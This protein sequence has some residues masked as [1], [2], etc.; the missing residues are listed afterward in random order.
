MKTHLHNDD[1]D[2][3]KVDGQ[4]QR[5]EVTY[6]RLRRRRH[7]GHKQISTHQQSSVIRLTQ[8]HSSSR[9]SV[10]EQKHTH[11]VSAKSTTNPTH[12][13]LDE[14]ELSGTRVHQR[15]EVLVAGELGLDESTDVS[16]RQDTV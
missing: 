15:V 4:Q 14:V 5:F 10:R 16:L 3:Q 12:L 1:S 13:V 8:K 11:T 2:H 9:E 6:R 7:E